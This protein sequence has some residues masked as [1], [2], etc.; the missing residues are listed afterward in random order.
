MELQLFK[1][2]EFGQVR[3]ARNVK[4]RLD[5]EDVRQMDTRHTREGPHVT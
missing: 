2:E 3:I 1:N 4:T 5:P